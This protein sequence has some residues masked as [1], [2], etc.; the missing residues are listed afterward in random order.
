H[1]LGSETATSTMYFGPYGSGTYSLGNG[2]L[3]SSAVLNVFG[4]EYIGRYN[5]T[6]NFIQ[7]GG[8]H[9]LGSGTVASTIYLGYDNGSAGTYSL[10]G[11]GSASVY[12]NV[13]VGGS[14]ISPGG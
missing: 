10:G 4:Y 1:N 13:Y 11:T 5:G 8:T 12:G 14:D 6:G 3:A 2:S 9:D 7:T